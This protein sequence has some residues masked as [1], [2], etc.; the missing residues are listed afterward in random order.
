MAKFINW[1]FKYL[2][3]GWIAISYAEEENEIRKKLTN[4]NIKQMHKISKFYWI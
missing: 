3:S 4:K 2:K 1:F